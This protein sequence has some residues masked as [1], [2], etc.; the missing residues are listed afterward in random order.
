MQHQRRRHDQFTRLFLAKVLLSSLGSQMTRRPGFEL[1]QR[2]GQQIAENIHGCSAE[3]R[4]ETVKPQC[5]PGTHRSR[6]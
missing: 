3:D 5:D 4:L 1:V 6:R 2:A